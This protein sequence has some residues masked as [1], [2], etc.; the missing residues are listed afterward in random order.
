MS[1]AEVTSSGVRKAAVT[2]PRRAP[3]SG[4]RRDSRLHSPSETLTHTAITKY[5]KS[6][7]G[8]ATG[9]QPQAVRTVPSIAQGVPQATP[10]A[11]TASR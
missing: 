7:A 3:P 1:V 4:E 2:I 6:R 10:S 9:D 11:R 8:P 5:W